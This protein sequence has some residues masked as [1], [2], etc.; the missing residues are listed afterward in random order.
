MTDVTN[1]TD[2]VIDK[3]EPRISSGER[4]AIRYFQ[5]K[6][7]ACQETDCPGFFEHEIATHGVPQVLNCASCGSGR[8]VEPN[9]MIAA[10]IGMRNMGECNAKGVLL[11]ELAA[12]TP[13]NSTTSTPTV[14]TVN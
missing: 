11:T 12:A 5:Y 4:E 10:G 6:C 1:K 14:S 7:S 9:K 13:T 3:V 8:G 2:E